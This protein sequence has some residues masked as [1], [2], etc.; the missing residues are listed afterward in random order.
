M[1]CSRSWH[2][3]VDRRTVGQYRETRLRTGYSQMVS[4]DSEREEPLTT[5]NSAFEMGTKV[6]SSDV[7]PWGHPAAQGVGEWRLR[8]GQKSVVGRVVMPTFERLVLRHQNQRASALTSRFRD[9]SSSLEN[10]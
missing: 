1:G 7:R 9:C 4:Q 8:L 10:F 5:P 2:S 3:D 6:S